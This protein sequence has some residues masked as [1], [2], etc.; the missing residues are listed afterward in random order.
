MFSVAF[1]YQKEVL[2]IKVGFR[3]IT[4]LFMRYHNHNQ[5]KLNHKVLYLT[6]EL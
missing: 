6:C 1:K 3:L 4:L 5:L 2:I